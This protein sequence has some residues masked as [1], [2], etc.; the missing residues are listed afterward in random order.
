MD[1]GAHERALLARDPHGEVHGLHEAVRSVVQRR[2]RHLHP[3]QLAHH[4]LELEQR[5]QHALRQLRLIGGIGG[6]ELGARRQRPDGGRDVVV[7]RSPAGEADEVRRPARSTRE[8]GHVTDQL[9][10]AERLRHIEGSVQ[11]HRAGDGLEQVV[12]LPG[13]DRIQHRAVV[14]LG[15][16]QEI[17]A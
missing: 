12:E 13:P 8:L 4:G 14:V 11:S 1:R 10:L 17:H 2:V 9:R 6:R 3:V 7:V 15:V 5:L 16:R